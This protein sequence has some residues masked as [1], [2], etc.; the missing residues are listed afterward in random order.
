MPSTCHN[1]GSGAMPERPTVRGVAVA[2]QRPRRVAVLLL[3]L[4]LL[5]AL[6]LAAPALAKTISG[7]GRDNVL[8]G[9]NRPDTI[10]GRGGEDTLR[11]QRGP[12]RLYGQ[13]GD[14]KI[15]GGRGEDRI[16]GGSGIDRQLGQRGNDRILTAGARPDVVDCGR[17]R[18]DF[19]RVDPTDKVRNCEEVR[20]VRPR[21]AS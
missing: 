8:V 10:Y 20:T 17:G 19:A 12:D 14:D 7:N 1:E 18:H 5:V 3:A 2:E 13:N 16:Y 9:T 6:A 21:A 11:G 15:V 4:A